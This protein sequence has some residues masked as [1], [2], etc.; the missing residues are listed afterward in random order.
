ME[1]QVWAAPSQLFWHQILITGD[2]IEG[3]NDHL[4]F[5]GRLSDHAGTDA[6]GPAGDSRKSQHLLDLTKS[7]GS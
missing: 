4:V 7:R 3:G 2:C 1:K 5:G 6:G